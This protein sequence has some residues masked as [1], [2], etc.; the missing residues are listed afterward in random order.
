MVCH[1]INEHSPLLSP[2]GRPLTFCTRPV[3]SRQVFDPA[4]YV[5]NQG[6]RLCE[7]CTFKTSSTCAYCDVCFFAC[8]PG[9]DPISNVGA[10]ATKWSSTT[11]N[12][13]AGWNHRRGDFLQPH[14]GVCCHGT[15]TF[16]VIYLVFCAFRY[17]FFWTA[18]NQPC[19]PRRCSSRA[20][21]KNICQGDIKKTAAICR[22]FVLCGG[23]GPSHSSAFPTARPTRLL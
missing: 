12:R 5:L 17:F 13:E 3:F 2:L 16:R 14:N 8:H 15:C 4:R 23:V 19:R 1:F 22:L 7:T 18:S 6:S 11:V 20:H 9:L 21:L 10:G